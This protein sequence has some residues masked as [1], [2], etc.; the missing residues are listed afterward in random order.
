MAFH[1]K[2]V[3]VLTSTSSHGEGNIAPAKRG[4]WAQFLLTLWTGYNE[5]LKFFL[6]AWLLILSKLLENCNKLFLAIVVVVKC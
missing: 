5:H 2:Q 6:T 1:L 3:L 4:K